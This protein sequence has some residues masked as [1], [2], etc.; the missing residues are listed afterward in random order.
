MSLDSQSPSAPYESSSFATPQAGALWVLGNV[1]HM[2]TQGNVKRLILPL[3]RERGSAFPRTEGPVIWFS[4]R[5]P[6]RY[7]FIAAQRQSTTLSAEGAVAPL[8]A[9]EHNPPPS[10]GH[11]PRP[12]GPSTFP[13]E[14]SEPGPQSGP[15]APPQP[16][17][18]KGPV[19]PENPPAEGRSILRTFSVT[20]LLHN[21]QRS[22]APLIF[23]HVMCYNKHKEFYYK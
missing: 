5:P 7:I 2:T 1:P 23:I 17:G 6:G 18:R 21:L 15:I 10:G 4:H 22:R 16:S 19:K 9:S 11:N 3:H 12:E 20:T 13:S 8:S 14:P